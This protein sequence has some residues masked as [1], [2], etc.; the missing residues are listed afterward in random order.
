M[1]KSILL[2]TSLVLLFAPNLFAEGNLRCLSQDQ[3]PM[4]TSMGW[5]GFRE[6]YELV[7]DQGNSIGKGFET[8]KSCKNVIA[9]MKTDRP[10]IC[11]ENESGLSGAIQRLTGNHTFSI[12]GPDGRQYGET[13]AAGHKSICNTLAM[14][15]TLKGVCLPVSKMLKY[16]VTEGDIEVTKEKKVSDGYELWG[17]GSKTRFIDHKDCLKM[18]E[19]LLRTEVTRVAKSSP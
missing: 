11:L 14:Q 17:S 5:I 18:A 7:N 10:F 6:S 2:F 4:L 8:E 3:G 12:F 9:K 16:K 15:G 13:F 19:S 1:S